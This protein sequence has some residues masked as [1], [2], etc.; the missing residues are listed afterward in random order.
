[1][2]SIKE[3]ELYYNCL[4]DFVCKLDKHVTETTGKSYGLHF[5]E[6][7]EAIYKAK[8]LDI[9]RY[10]KS[11]GGKKSARNMTKA[12]RSERARKAGRASKRTK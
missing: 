7:R 2:K 10:K 12:E 6:L 9:D 5:L 11:Q 1:M 3:I 8:A 4:D